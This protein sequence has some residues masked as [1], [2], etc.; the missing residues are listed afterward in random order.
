V[1]DRPHYPHK[2]MENNNLFDLNAAIRIWRENL[3]QSPSFRGDDIEE[4]ESHLRDSV[5]QL[6]SQNLSEDEAFTIATRRVGPGAML[7]AEFGRINTSG[8]WMDRMLWML[9]GAVS[10]SIVQSWQSSVS[11][12]L[13]APNGFSVFVSAILWVSPLILAGLVLR[14][15]A[16]PDGSIPQ[17]MTNLVRNPG[18]LSLTFMVLGLFS[19][20]LRG[21]AVS[22]VAGHPQWANPIG[23][24][25]SGWAIVAL[26]I[27]VLARRRLQPMQA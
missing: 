3:A 14:S 5:T 24:T 11:L 18:R 8:L 21:W 10:V 25:L 20:A 4:L 26:L 12:A 2:I 22:H 6:Q 9:L 27:F 17:V 7:S 23:L 15:L 1:D 19:I 13:I 16:R